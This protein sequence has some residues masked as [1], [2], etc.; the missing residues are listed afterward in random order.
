[1]KPSPDGKHF[2][3]SSRSEQATGAIIENHSVR[4]HEDRV[5]GIHN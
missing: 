4:H 1:M 3:R 2:R 5:I